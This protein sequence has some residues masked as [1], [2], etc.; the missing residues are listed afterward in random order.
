MQR[1]RQPVQSEHF[2]ILITDVGLPGTDP[3]LKGH[4]LGTVTDTAEL[5]KAKGVSG[6]CF[7]WGQLSQ[8]WLWLLHPQRDAGFWETGELARP[9]P[10][11]GKEHLKVRQK[12]A[13]AQASTQGLLLVPQVSPIRLEFLNPRQKSP[14]LDKPP[15]SGGI[16]RPAYQEV[17][18]SGLC[19]PSQPGASKGGAPLPSD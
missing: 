7:L 14:S 17:L 3:R 1:Q 11:E 18:C 9:I 10:G 15:L 8:S 19:L 4:I 12:P 2:L 6:M 5:P 13:K 16:S